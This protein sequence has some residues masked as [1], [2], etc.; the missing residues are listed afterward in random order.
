MN[1][2]RSYNYST[3]GRNNRSNPFVRNNLSPTNFPTSIETIEDDVSHLTEQISI[4]T[5][6]STNKKYSS[7][8]CNLN[9]NMVLAM[10]YVPWQ[11][12]SKPFLAAD[13][14]MHGTMFPELVKPFEGCNKHKEPMTNNCYNTNTLR[15]GKC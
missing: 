14:L 11:K 2:Y 4:Q 12:W 5:A 8:D 13:G 15:G 3:S 6:S 7:C 9:S 10:A 1:N